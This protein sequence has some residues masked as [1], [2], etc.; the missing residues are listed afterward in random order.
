[1]KK[2]TIA[3]LVGTIIIF[4]WSAL[5]WT[6]LPV[7]LRSFHYTPKQDS[8]MNVLNSSLPGS[9]AYLLP[10]ADNRNVG[11]FDSKYREAMEDNMKKAEGK[12]FAMIFYWN[13]TF[14]MDPMQFILGFLFDMFSVMFAVVIFVMAK[15]KFN[16]F[17]MRWWVFIMIGALVAF[18]AHMVEWNWLHFQWHFI[19]GMVIDDVMGWSLCGAW[20]AWYLGKA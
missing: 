20:L 16:T 8:V 12:P 17:F 1:M 18:N 5:S 3:T 9:G 15:D 13:E 2:F 14:R 19:K 11:M 7:H 6:M 4:I 10:S